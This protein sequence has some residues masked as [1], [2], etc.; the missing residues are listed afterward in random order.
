M[1]MINCKKITIFFIAFSFIFTSIAYAETVEE[2]KDKINDRND[3]ISK[4]E[5]EIRQYQSDIDALG[6]EKDSLSNTIKSKTAV[7]WAESEDFRIS[8]SKIN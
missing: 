5:S 4:L 8:S 6:K 1:H 2:I 3:A 7:I